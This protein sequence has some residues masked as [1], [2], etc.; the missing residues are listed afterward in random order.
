MENQSAASI[1]EQA[2]EQFE[3]QLSPQRDNLSA[4]IGTYD[5]SRVAAAEPTDSDL[6]ALAG[7]P[8]DLSDLDAL[9]SESMQ[10]AASRKRGAS[11]RDASQIRDCLLPVEEPWTVVANTALWERTSCL[12]GMTTPA[13]FIHYKEQRTRRNTTVWVKV[14]A[15]DSSKPLT[16]VLYQ[17]TT[18]LCEDCCEVDIDEMLGVADAFKS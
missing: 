1:V 9:L 18:T 2:Y 16:H 8:D 12:C 11:R 7:L 6:A 14:P 3:S 13:M 15:I 17:R 4:R 5:L 10:Q